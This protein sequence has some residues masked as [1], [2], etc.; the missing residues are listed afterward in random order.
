[1]T[2]ELIDFREGSNLADVTFTTGFDPAKYKRYELHL[3]NLVE[4]NPAVF[5]PQ[6]VL[7]LSA[8]GT[9]FDAGPNYHSSIGYSCNAYA[10]IDPPN[11][12]TNPFRMYLAHYSK[13]NA[14]IYISLD[15]AQ[16]AYQGLSGKLTVRSPGVVAGLNVDTAIEGVLSRGI[17]TNNLMPFG[18]LVW[19]RWTGAVGSAV[20]G[21]RIKNNLQPMRGRVELWGV[22]ET[23]SVGGSIQV[24]KGT[25]FYDMAGA[26]P[27]PVSI[28]VGFQPK[29]VEFRCWYN[30]KMG[31][32]DCD[33]TGAGDCL[34]Q[35]DDAGVHKANW[36]SS[37]PIV[38]A[39]T[40]GNWVLGSIA[41]NPT[42]FTITY[43]KVGAPTGGL[44][45]G[46]TAV[47]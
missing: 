47:G 32:G 27:P 34:F 7:T 12:P 36:A 35:Y 26:V 21:I 5:G 22:S 37:N 20:K 15:N 30:D 40:L 29:K 4:M 8:D 3:D 17:F 33:Q 14:G 31:I 16:N 13:E 10:P 41:I 6:F 46:Y 45:V 42:G 2:K 28:N 39:T 11:D 24:K 43:S 38:G 1:M 23:A 19:G 18:H 9:T 44:S 25:T